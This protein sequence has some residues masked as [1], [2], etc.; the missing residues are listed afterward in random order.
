VGAS[1][2]NGTWAA[3]AT[4]LIAWYQPASMSMSSSCGSVNIADSSSHSGWVTVAVSR[5]W[6]TRRMTTLSRGWVQHGSSAPPKASERRWFADRPARSAKTAACTPNSYSHPQRAVTRSMMTSRRRMSS[7]R[8]RLRQ[9]PP[10]PCI[11]AVIAGFLAKV[12]NSA[13]G[14]CPAGVIDRSSG[15]TSSSNGSSKGTIRIA[16]PVGASVIEAYYTGSKSEAQR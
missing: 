1:S 11:A 7:D 8:R 12:R 10:H 2:S 6:S 14:R 15:P 9:Y 16:S 4:K 13:I 5:N 3:R